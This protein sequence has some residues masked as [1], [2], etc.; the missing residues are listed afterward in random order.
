[1]NKRRNPSRFPVITVQTTS[2]RG[3]IRGRDISK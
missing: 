2:Y 1:L 3:V